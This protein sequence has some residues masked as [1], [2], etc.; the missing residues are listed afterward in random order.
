MLLHARETRPYNGA[1]GT[2]EN[3][4]R[5]PDHP[6]SLFEG[7]AGTVC[8]WADACAVLRA[9]LRKMEL[10]GVDV[11]K[12]QDFRECVQQQLGFPFLGGNGVA[13]VL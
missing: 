12:D 1:T 11:E 13:G 6:Y 5:V 4:Y 8:A 2:T 3:E 7:L 10:P 9:R